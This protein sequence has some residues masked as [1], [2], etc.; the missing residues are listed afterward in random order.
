MKRL[1]LMVAIW[2]VPTAVMAQGVPAAFDAEPGFV[3]PLSTI[4]SGD[5]P[6]STTE[7]SPAKARTVRRAGKTVMLNH[8]SR[9]SGATSATATRMANAG[10]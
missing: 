1:S 4:G 10:S 6:P 8:A 5:H 2:L 7:T 3:A 9:P